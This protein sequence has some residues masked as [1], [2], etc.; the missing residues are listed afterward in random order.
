MG[1]EQKHQDLDKAQLYAEAAQALGKGACVNVFAECSGAGADAA[2]DPDTARVQA[3]EAEQRKSDANYNIQYIMGEEEGAAL[4]TGRIAGANAAS[5]G[6][7]MASQGSNKDKKKKKTDDILHMMV[8]LQEQLE[9]LDQQIAD[10]QA[11]IDQLEDEIGDIE[12]DL[13]ERYGPDWKEKLMRGELDD[14]PQARAWKEKSEELAAAREQKAELIRDRDTYRDQLDEYKVRESELRQRIDAGDPAAAK[15]LDELAEEV[16][17]VIAKDIA[18]REAIEN[19]ETSLTSE[20]RHSLEETTSVSSAN[21]LN[22]EEEVE[23]F[24]R[25]FAKSKSI[26]DP[27]ERLQREKQLVDGLSR[28]V[29]RDLSFEEDTEKLFEDGY[30]DALEANAG[31]TLAQAP[32]ATPGTPSV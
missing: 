11:Q 6:A 9:W 12:Q 13:A 3:R 24:M 7:E 27:V 15:E 10:I 32:G 23:N 5:S 18:A 28:R 16:N 8:L 19:V 26:N 4:K 14:D 2:N 25:E 17:A 22:K 29:A 31:T 21:R 30:F 1:T 20:E